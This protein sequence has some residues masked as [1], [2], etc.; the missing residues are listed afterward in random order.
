MDW[1][2]QFVWVWIIDFEFSQPPGERPRVACLVARE[3]YTERF[4]RIGCEEINAMDRPP[5]DV[6]NDSLFIAYFSSAEWNC[7]RALGWSLPC[8][9]LDLWCEF[10]NLL[11]GST[12]PAGWGLLG[13]L[14]YHGLDSMDA[15]EKSEMRDL[16]IRGGPFT[17]DEMTALLDYCQTDVDALDRLLPVML[18]RIDFPRAVHR[19]RFMVA[20]SAMEHSG[21]PIDSATLALVRQQWPSIKTRL[22][23]AVDQS[24]GVYD[25]HTF[26]LDRF[27]AYLVRE[28]IP[29][30]ETESG[31]LALDEET[32]R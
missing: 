12:P 30:P 19:G 4:V 28:G 1:L 13:C 5:F 7:F 8:R 18:P 27:A 24:Y 11:N 31:R 17:E 9:V 21:I 15:S 6:S 32:F 26:K 3:L 14:A 20:V 10:R 2:K 29:W 16:A 23:D 22:I 25:G